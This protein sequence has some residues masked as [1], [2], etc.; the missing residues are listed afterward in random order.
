MKI[1]ILFL[2]M[3][4]ILTGCQSSSD[5]SS[6]SSSTTTTSQE[7]QYAGMNGKETYT[8]AIQYFNEKVKYYHSVINDNGNKTVNE[9]Y[10]Y[11]G[12]ISIVS[13]GW[14]DDGG[15]STLTYTITSGHDFHTLFLGNEGT[16]EYNVINDY[17]Q[18]IH[19][20]YNDYTT[21]K[22]CEIIDIQ[23]SDENSQIILTLKLKIVEQYQQSDAPVTNYV[24][25]TMTIDKDGYI[26]EE[27]LTNYSDESFKNISSEGN[28][29]QNSLFNQKKESDFDKEIELMKSCQGLNNEEVKEKLGI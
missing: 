10:N 22:N 14:Y 29:V 6:S 1:K 2:A 5:S 28:H 11:N 12:E 9:N 4:I 8:S 3:L 21:Q 23:R 17:P 18:E 25:S 7:T 15:S 24:M 19:Q 16:Y 20:M 26:S 27:K 13:K